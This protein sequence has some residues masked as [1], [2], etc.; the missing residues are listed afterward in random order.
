LGAF[1]RNQ[2][3]FQNLEI[4]RQTSL[5]FTTYSVWPFK[6]ISLEQHANKIPWKKLSWI[7]G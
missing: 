3:K 5:F 7:L 6:H 1:A 2:T 4:Q